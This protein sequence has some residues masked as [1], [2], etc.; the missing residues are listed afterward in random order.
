MKKKYAVICVGGQSN[1][2][3]YDESVI[4][5]NYREQFHTERLWQLGFYGED[6]LKI[7]PLLECAQ[8]FQDMRPYGNP[9]NEREGLG[10][11]GIH[12]PLGEQLLE[13]VSMDTDI[14]VLPCAYGGTGFLEGEEGIYDPKTKKPSPGILRWGVNSP[15]YLSLKDRLKYVLDLKEDSRFL[16]MVWI[17]GESD[18]ACSVRHME[19]FQEM[20]EDFLAYFQ[21]HYPKRAY[22]KWD[23]NLWYNVETAAY[24]YDI[25]DCEKIWNGYKKFHPS[26]CVAIPRSTD[27]NKENGT[28]MTAKVREAHFGNNAF[29]HVIA[30]LVAEK[31]KDVRGHIR[32]KEEAAKS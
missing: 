16:A 18:H 17:Q 23:R 30:P 10:T 25:G 1:A 13:L 20:A 11:K 24:W 19:L 22:G 8:N 12:L 7:I 21:K 26:T 6:N 9:D 31:I 15:Y 32:D 29:W 3:G 27:T 5:K 28:G 14:L 2:V 4:T